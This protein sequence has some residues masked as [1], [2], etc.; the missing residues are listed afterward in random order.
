MRYTSRRGIVHEVSEFR[1]TIR[2]FRL[3][4]YYAKTRCGQTV[5]ISAGSKD[6]K[7]IVDCKNCIR[8]IRRSIGWNMKAIGE[9][10]N[11]PKDRTNECMGG[12]CTLDADAR[13]RPCQRFPCEYW[14]AK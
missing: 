3:A 8:E 5:L 11:P 2:A 7:T 12:I 1:T 6:Y 9:E 14:S 10:Y 4:T 13:D